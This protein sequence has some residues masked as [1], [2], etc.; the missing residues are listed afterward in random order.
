MWQ[1]SP[2]LDSSEF[3]ALLQKFMET[4]QVDPLLIQ[5]VSST[6]PALLQKILKK[7]E[8]LAST[9]VTGP[10][11]KAKDYYRPSK[12]KYELKWPLKPRPLPFSFDELDPATQFEF[13]FNDWVRHALEGTQ[14][15]SAG[16]MTGA[17]AIFQECLER[18]QQLDVAELKARSLEWLMRVAQKSG[19]RN[20]ERKWLTATKDARKKMGIEDIKLR[21][22]EAMLE[23]E[24][25]R[26]PQAEAEMS[27]IISELRGAKK[28]MRSELC[29]SLLYRAAVLTFAT[30]WEEALNDL[31]ECVEVA[32]E[33]KPINRREVLASVYQTEI[34]IYS[35]PFARVANDAAVREAVSNLNAVSGASLLTTQTNAELAYREGDW[36]TAADGFRKVAE[37]LAKEGWVRSVAGCRSRS[38]RALLELNE[39]DAAERDLNAAHS[40]LESHGSP[41]MLA[42]TKMHLARLSLERGNVEEAWQLAEDGLQLVES[43]IRKFGALIDQ[44]HF[45]LSKLTAYQC[46][47][48]VALAKPGDQGT[49]RAWTVAERAKSFYLCHLV[50]NADVDLFEGID[51][52]KLAELRKLEAELDQLEVRLSPTLLS[53]TEQRGEIEREFNRISKAKEELQGSLMRANP[54]WGLLKEPPQ[55]DLRTELEKLDSKWVPVSYF[56]QT[57]KEGATLHIFST[58]SNRRPL[59]AT[60]EWS[61]DELQQLDQTRERLRG[62]LSPL[63]SVLPDELAAKILPAEVLDAFAPDQN[64]LIS[65]HDRLRMLPL[66][67][68]TI[69]D[70]RLI[71]L[72]PVMYI[73]TLA[74]LPFRRAAKRV[75]QVLLMGCE[76]DG[77]GSPPLKQVPDEIHTL[78]KV[79]SQSRPGKTRDFLL[80]SHDSPSASGLPVE[81]W[82]EFDVL[83]F[84]CHGDF[85]EGRPFDAALRLGSDAVRTSEFFGVRLNATVISLSACALARQ[86]REHSGIKLT[87]DEWLGLYLPLF[88]AGARGVVASLWD[89][90][91][92]V[93]AQLMKEFHR[94][95]SESEDLAGSFR[96]AMRSVAQKPEALWANW[97]LVGF[98]N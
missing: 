38:G 2:Q 58:S 61:H 59:H 53:G 54:R 43:S 56:W 82:S 90:N 97:C 23:F 55:L 40:F 71:D 5:C 22:E 64:L 28:E 62:V 96:Q 91:S 57:R 37:A 48:E 88:Y 3:D 30:R 11:L 67:A 36:K 81:E 98:P 46:A 31:R 70:Q 20:A 69:A 27:S 72:R 65:P 77:F 79:W 33:L 50:A 24:D 1:P 17:E 94:A 93:A 74:L 44:Q 19:D 25:G 12:T 68:M 78:N 73:P 35:I 75:E 89:A 52:M 21:R 45:I 84:A 95:L 15:L 85:P 92:Q 51:P 29:Q 9:E 26:L 60:V 86:T 47:F 83:H 16:D 76:Q 41:D 49:W 80:S 66:H 6:D 87:G 7:L 18:A 8:E 63:A 39:L 14:A 42:T 34:M 13:L 10:P 32:Q 4:G